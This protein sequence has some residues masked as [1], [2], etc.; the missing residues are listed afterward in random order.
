LGCRKR[1]TGKMQPT[2][3]ITSININNMESKKSDFI[4]SEFNRYLFMVAEYIFF[5]MDTR[6]F[7]A[8]HRRDIP[9]SISR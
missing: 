1:K 3:E 5:T 2:Y 7:T 6:Q 9:K 4:G 8:V